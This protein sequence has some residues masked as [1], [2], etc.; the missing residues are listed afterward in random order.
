MNTDPFNPQSSYEAPKSSSPY[1][2]FEKG[3]TEFMPLASAVIG[4]LYWTNDNKPVRLREQPTGN[5][6]DLPDI[7]P[8]KDGKF[9]VKHFWAFPAIDL[10]DGKVKILEITQQSI[11]A[12]IRVYAQN[13]KWGT[14]IQRYTFTVH[15]DGEGLDT[16]YT[17]M[18]NPLQVVPAEWLN[19]WEIASKS[20]F[21][22]TELFD[23]GDP[24]N[25]KEKPA[26]D[27]TPDHKAPAPEV[28]QVREELP[29]DNAVPPDATAAS[30]AAVSPVTDT[31]TTIVP[32]VAPEPA[33]SLQTV[34]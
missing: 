9:S 25:P 10:L 32:D 24:F 7:R 26:A 2:K 12:A 1:L 33:E 16:E 28:A 19:A 17:V 31:E 8:E 3:N 6:A 18:A 14:P 15:R 5:Y 34:S 22:I 13:P 11:Q 20:G 27:P 23:G 29:A 30:Q 21:D 4:W